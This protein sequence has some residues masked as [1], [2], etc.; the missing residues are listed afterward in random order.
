MKKIVFLLLLGLFIISCRNG[1]KEIQYVIDV[2][3]DT[4][5]DGYAFLQYRS[6][7]EWVKIDSAMIDQASFSFSGNA[8]FPSM[9]YIYIAGLKRNIPVFVDDGKIIITVSGND[10]AAT[11]VEGSAAHEQY[12]AFLTESRRYDKVISELY[13]ELKKTGEPADTIIRDSIE[14]LLDEAWDD[15]Q[16]YIRDYVFIY[17]NSPVSPY[18]AYSYSYSWTVEEL[19]R[20]TGNFSSDLYS[21]SYYQR[22]MDRI[23]VLKKVAVGQPL[24]DF[25]MKDTSGTDVRLS[26]ISKG[27]YFLVDFWAAWCGPC[28]AENPNIVACYRD[29]NAKGF[30]VLGVSFDDDRE[31]WIKA[32]HD[33]SLGWHHVS[34][35]QGWKNEAGQLYGI[36]SIPSS[37][38]LDSDGIIIEK[39]LRGEDLRQKLEELMP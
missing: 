8:I 16:E 27:K 22:I 19:E 13:Q 28:R 36:R 39:N 26:E 31:Q 32:I 1:K 37:V 23:A 29:F 6:D 3:L 25:I 15:Q 12:D 35:L 10:P 11:I 24:T 34:D 17:N 7:G 33:D 14:K 9:N 30:D 18:I 5:V 20:I 2:S 38:L 21:S 4:L